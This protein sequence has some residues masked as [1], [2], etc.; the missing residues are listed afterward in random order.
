MSATAA[1]T[2]LGKSMSVSFRKGGEPD[3]PAILQLMAQLDITGEPGLSVA[4]GTRILQKIASYPNYSIS[5]A[6]DGNHQ[7]LGTFALLVM[8]NLAHRG[9]PSAIVED[10]CV[11]E[12]SRGHGIGH[13]M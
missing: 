13:A 12:G 8:D 11:Y 3:I 5:V 2:G 1:E 7:V 4:E 9:A 10:V 6:E